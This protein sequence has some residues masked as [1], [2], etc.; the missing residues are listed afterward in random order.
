MIG[1]E[2]DANDTHTDKYAN[3]ALRLLW[4]NTNKFESFVYLSQTIHSL[5]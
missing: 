4:I 1:P 5:I 2:N 3:F